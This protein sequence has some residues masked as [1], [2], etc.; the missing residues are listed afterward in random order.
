[1]QIPLLN[2]IY[3]SPDSDLRTS[4]P[5]NMVPV[6]K[7]SGISN[8]YLRPSDG[9]K[10]FGPATPGIDRGGINWNG[11][12]YRVTGSTLARIGAD[13]S[14]IE[15]GQVGPGDPVSLDYSFD[16]LA[17][18]SGGRLYYYDGT[19]LTQVTDVDLGTVKDM[20]WV[21]DYFMTTDGEFIIVT[22][23]N[24]PYSVNPL[25]YGSSEADPDPIVALKKIRD[26]IY[27]LNRYTTEV[28]QNVGGDNF[29]YQRLDGAQIPRG[30]I[31]T[32]ACAKYLESIA[33]LGSGR[34]EAPSVYL[35]A[36]GNTQKLAT[37]EID[38]I[39]LGYTEEQLQTAHMDVKVDKA[40][41]H[42]YIH[43]PDQTL[44][45]DAAASAVLGEP[46]WFTLTS[47]VAGLGAY[48]VRDLVW[49]YGKWVFGDPLT[50]RLGELVTDVSSHFGETV[51]W[52][53]GVQALF[54]EGRGA[55]V[56]E[57]EL[58][59]LT[60]ASAFGA[61]PVIWTSYS[62]DGQTWSM[63]RDIASGERGQTRKR[64]C[65][66]RCGSMRNW[67]TQKFRGTSDT[68]VAFV[69]LDMTIEPLA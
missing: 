67:R 56:H 63:E 57:I 64:L 13:G 4:L 42:L 12:L 32:K 55:I 37:R 24:D 68:H 52:D 9:L 22:D 46:V 26:E 31:G 51:G 14:Y 33:F 25:K 7:A 66:R 20:L 39:L 2:G 19:D 6:P 59:A 48:Q 45:F 41:Q 28:F 5:R 8:G 49:V 18:A 65:W 35:A 61:K 30:C 29:P 27:A 58:V 44:V 11:T 15:I 43:L 53:F 38:Q 17:I 10:A 40:H 1:M 36:N 54:N 50:P 47:S 60:G 34:N 21:D 69:R 16:R 23:L 3:A 62:L